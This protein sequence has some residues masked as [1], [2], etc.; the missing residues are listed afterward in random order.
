MTALLFI[1]A[2]ALFLGIDYLL[3]RR[4]ARQPLVQRVL[5]LTS[6][7][8]QVPRGL[9]YTSNHVW[10][11]V[12]EDGVLTMGVDELVKK[13]L[14]NVGR[15]ETVRPG[16]VIKE[17]DPLITLYQGNRRLT[18]KS[19][20]AG[21]VKMINAA[22]EYAPDEYLASP[23]EDGWVCRLEPAPDAVPVKTGIMG[24]AALNWMKEEI[25]RLTE[26][27]H[28]EVNRNQGLAHSM[29]DGGALPEG[30]LSEMDDKIWRAVERE[31]F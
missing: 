31:L 26:I 4:K 21:K 19:P 28:Y 25:Q 16:T 7:F 17:N 27:I 8:L 24:E 30:I 15:V 18:I 22:L 5:P 1:T 10:Y 14:G 20:F 6:Q 12:E 3:Q 2:L 23:Y 11:K 29:L 13:T 9:F